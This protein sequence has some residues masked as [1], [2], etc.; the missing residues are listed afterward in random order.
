MRALVLALVL[1]CADDPRDQGEL[2][3]DFFGEACVAAPYPAATTC[4]DSR[5]W[6]IDET[7]R[8]MCGLCGPGNRR[9]ADSG[10]CYCELEP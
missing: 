9:Y 4:H 5:G 8:P 3:V 1:G 7:C 2:E 10:A 6:C